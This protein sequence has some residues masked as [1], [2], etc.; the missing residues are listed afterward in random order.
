MERAS[1]RACA[2]HAGRDLEAAAAVPD[3][4]CPILTKDGVSSDELAAGQEVPEIRR[5]P[6]GAPRLRGQRCVA[7][8][9]CSHPHAG[10][11]DVARGRSLRA[12]P[13]PH[14][15]PGAG[16]CFSKAHPGICHIASA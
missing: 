2:P 3:I 6:G 13:A 1:R 4:F 15:S 5:A 8:G 12:P 9:R 11:A 7:P 16:L 10:T 14:N